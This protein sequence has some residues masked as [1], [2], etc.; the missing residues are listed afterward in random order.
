MAVENV[1]NVEWGTVGRPTVGAGR[2]G[3]QR[4]AAPTIGLGTGCAKQ[5]AKR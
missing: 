4:T 1:E 5:V 3:P 2:D